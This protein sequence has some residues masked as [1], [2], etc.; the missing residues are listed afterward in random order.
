M[1]G[2]YCALNSGACRVL[3]PWLGAAL[4]LPRYGVCVALGAGMHACMRKFGL[5]LPR[6]ISCEMAARPTT[7]VAFG[8]ALLAAALATG[9]A[10]DPNIP[11]SHTGTL[12]P[13]KPGPPPPLTSAELESLGRGKSVQ[14]TVKLADSTGARDTITFGTASKRMLEEM[15]LPVLQRRL[16]LDPW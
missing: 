11:H 5:R 2:M 14:K 9:R 13:F 4:A 1:G 12:D 3:L 16:R 7:R 15:C 6:K 8:R 10:D